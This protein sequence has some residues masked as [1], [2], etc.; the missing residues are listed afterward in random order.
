VWGK[1]VKEGKAVYGYQYLTE[2]GCKHR[3]VEEEKKDAESKKH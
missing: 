2:E 3:E 1:T